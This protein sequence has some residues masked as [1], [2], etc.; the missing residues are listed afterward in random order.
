MDM[1]DLRYNPT[2]NFYDA[3]IHLK[4]T[5]GV[6]VIDDFGRQRVNAKD[7]LNRWIVPLEER[8]DYL[9]LHTGKKFQIPFD[10][11]TFFATNLDPED[12]VDDAF[13]RRIRYQIPMMGPKRNVLE[14][15]FRL[16]LRAA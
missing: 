12:L 7:L 3:P 6:L 4:A 2:T 5:G 15:I 13:L 1:L 16:V 10:Q 9:S 11:L 14:S 8:H